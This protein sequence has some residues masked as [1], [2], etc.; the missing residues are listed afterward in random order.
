MF[1][2]F[3][4]VAVCASLIIWHFGNLGNPQLESLGSGTVQIFSRERVESPLALSRQDLGFAFVYSVGSNNAA[5]LRAKFSV[6]DG[7][8]ITLDNFK[9]PQAIMHKMG[10]NYRFSQQNQFMQVFYGY[11]PRGRD[12][13]IRGRERINMQIAVRDGRVTVGWPVILGSF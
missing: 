10:V 5:A 12:F 3:V 13:I 8:A 6:I 7:E 4:F 9:N 2:L 11:S 1:K